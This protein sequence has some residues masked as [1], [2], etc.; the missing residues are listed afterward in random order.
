MKQKLTWWQIAKQ[1]LTYLFMLGLSTF[2]SEA[3]AE[4]FRLR[5]ATIAEINQAFEKNALTS[6]QL[7]QL[8]LNRIKAYDD[9][10]PEINGLISINNNALKEARELDQERQQKGPRSPLHG[11]PIILKDNYDTT[12]L[13]TT[14]GS[15]L[16][17]GSLPPDDAF[18]VKKLREA[19]AIILGKANMSEFAESYGRLGY[20]S[21]GGLTRNPY[22]LTRDPSGSS[23]GS[24][25][26]IAA[27]FAVLATGSD[28][29]GSIR[30]PAAVAGL[31]GIKPTQGLVSRD[32]IIPLTL[33]FDSAGPMARTVTDAAIALG[34]MAGVDPNDYRTLESEGKTY[35][36]YTQFLN[37]KALKGARIGVA[38]DFRGGNPEVDAATDAAVAK[39][40]ELGA[41]VESVDF[42]PKLENLWPF[43][44]EVT[45]AE[46]EPQIDS[47]LKN[48][49]LPFPDTLREMYS[50]SLSNPLV[51]SEQA[52]NPGRVGGFGE[53]LKHPELA[54]TEYLYI[55]HFEFPR[56]RQ[57]ILSIMSAQNL[58]AIIWPTMTCPAGPLYNVEDPTY[59]CASN[60]PYIPGYLANVSGFPGISVAMG[61]TEQ[62]LPL[63]LTFFGKPYSEPTLL[64]FAYAYE[65]ATQFRRPPTTTPALPGENFDY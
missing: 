6:E 59:Q 62:G 61:F 56:V 48:L 54:D 52:L 47:Y 24:G 14:G 22:K 31:V 58:D 10:G 27:N 60:D 42:S 29:S 1:G 7:V 38:I 50:M 28:T 43:M 53:S 30:G 55:L 41:T 26:V 49:Q 32:G 51:N 64:G 23:G 36:D 2:P 44:E 40:R 5:E 16:L 65:Q 8:Y 57:E 39:L 3:V 9:Q 34:V 35:K 46:F 13:P 25:A 17:E 37:K 20:S 45:E 11:I 63:G 4:T 21:L 12:D 33:S 19:G 15:V 18:T